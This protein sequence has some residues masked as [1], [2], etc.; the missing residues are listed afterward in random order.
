[1]DS[2]SGL[3][4]TNGW[5]MKRFLIALALMD[6]LGNT[7]DASAQVPTSAADSV[8]AWLRGVT[9]R[10]DRLEA[11]SCPPA[12]EFAPISEPLAADSL[13][14]AVW[15]IEV[16]VRRLIAL[17]CQA[18]AGVPLAVPDTLGN[19]LA[20]LRAAAAA[21]AGDTTRGPVAF[22]GQQRS[23]AALNPDIS[24]TGDVRFVVRDPGPQVDNAV[25]REFEVSFQSAL[26][27]YSHTKIFVAFSDEEI[28][29][30]EGYIY[31]TGLPGKLR[32][33]VGK[34]R[35][36]IGDLNRWHAHA[37]PET[38]YPLVYQ[39][40][41]G[42]EGL[43]GVGLSLYTALPVSVAGGTHEVYLQSTIAE[44]EPLF[45]ESR[46]L[47]LLGRVQNFWQVSR[48]TYMQIGVTGVGG[49]NRERDLQSRLVGADFR[50]TYRPPN[51]ATRRELTFR[52]E[53]YRLRATEVG[54]TTHRAGAFADLQFRASR[55]LVVGSRFDWV[56]TLHGARRS[57]WQWVPTLSWWQSEFVLLRLEGRHGRIDGQT[58]TQ[59]LAQVVWAMG[60][61]KHETY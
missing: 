54:A 7:G 32:V 8:Q 15:R 30:E 4:T 60:P 19:D 37:L 44:S 20:A 55:R 56:E 5:V 29:V 46:Q 3:P 41:F 17:R 9:V 38:D 59:L 61:H 42:D 47:S 45:G 57:D 21:T 28:A 25:A 27:P 2:P 34:F 39:R 6:L 14:R 49:N 33:D 36:Q 12:A 10:L 26:D 53:A 1:M 24:A 23:G 31:W 13:T 22:I 52:A 11:G 50:V 51:A 35:Q 40:M 16:R 18:S 43:A 58:M 48:S